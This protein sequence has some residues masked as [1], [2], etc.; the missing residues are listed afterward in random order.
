M[1]SSTKDEFTS[2]DVRLLLYSKK[3]ILAFSV[4]FSTIFGASLLMPGLFKIGKQKTAYL[5]L[6]GSIVYTILSVII[7]TI[8]ARPI[9]LLVYLFNLTGG[10]ILSQI[11][12]KSY[13]PHSEYHRKK[14]IW[15][16]LIISFIIMIP[17]LFAVIFDFSI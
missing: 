11:V 10:L 15:K 12:Y 4:V 1:E 6:L 3:V 17:L 14:K 5:I 9:L 8:P 2:I 16:P 13:F 7:I